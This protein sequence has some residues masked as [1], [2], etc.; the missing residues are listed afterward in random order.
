MN[1]R[2]S[3]HDIKIAKQSMHTHAPRARACLGALGVLAF[4]KLESGR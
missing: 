2:A 4:H 3:R 1:M